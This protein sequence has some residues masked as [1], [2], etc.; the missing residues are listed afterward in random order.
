MTGRIL[1]IDAD[2]AARAALVA[3]LE[4]AYLDATALSPEAAARVEAARSGDMARLA[5][6]DDPRGPYEA[7][8]DG[9]EGET[10]FDA[11]P[12]KVVLVNFWATWC[13]PCL[14]E[15]P[16]LDALSA[17]MESDEFEVVGI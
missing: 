11:W 17:A 6:H 12:G 13:P 9:P 15:M 4:A 7:S 10:G 1:V 8:F 2:P 3:R 5:V 14:K 16:S